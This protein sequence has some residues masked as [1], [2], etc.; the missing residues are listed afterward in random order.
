[1]S[2]ENFD[3]IEADGYEAAVEAIRKTLN[4]LDSLD[5]VAELRNDTARA[6]NL[7]ESQLS[8][9][10]S[11]QIE[12]AKLAMDILHRSTAFIDEFKNE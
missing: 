3:K 2:E 7:V 8:T 6:K 5:R 10:S 4:S 9:I 11:A 12:E 1:M